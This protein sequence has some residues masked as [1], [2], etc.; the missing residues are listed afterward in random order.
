M[1]DRYVYDNDDFRFRRQRRSFRSV[2]MRVLKYFLASVSLAVVY[3]IIF[4][5]FFSTDRERRLKSENRMFERLYPEMEQKQQLLEDVVSGLQVKDNIIYND[6]FHTDV[7]S[8]DQ[9]P[10]VD[11]L[12]GEDS[13]E[14]SEIVDYSDKRLSAL[15]PAA[16]KVDSDFREIF[17]MLSSGEVQ[18]PPFSLP[19][20]DF[21]YSSTGASTGYRINPFYKVKVRHDGLDMVAS[22]GTPVYASADGIVSEVVRSRKGLGNVVAIDHGNGYVTRYAHLSDIK[23]L[24]GRKVSKGDM[25][26]KVG[27]TGNSFAPHLH[28]EVWRDSVALDPVSYFFGSVT[29]EEYGHMLLLSASA[30]QSMD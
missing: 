6:L 16:D 17:R 10:T 1:G 7:I 23:V 4:A 8:F 24:R 21:S 13:L 3:Y 28:Y 25:V 20:K 9:N 5:L 29:P 30:G 22:A 27:V 14:V 18:L 15:R 12:A 11:F 2:L 26:G 19:L